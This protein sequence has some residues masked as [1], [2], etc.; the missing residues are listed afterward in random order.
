MS[1]VDL[2]TLY[3]SSYHTPDTLQ[4]HS[5][6]LLQSLQHNLTTQPTPPPSTFFLLSS[7]PLPTLSALSAACSWCVSELRCHMEDESDVRLTATLERIA[8]WS[9]LRAAV[10]ERV[11]ALQ[12][13]TEQGRH[14]RL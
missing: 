10:D 9:Q 7:L 14:S 12:S 5:Y 11:I 4:S 13:A 8:E 3:L 2:L 6:R 1:L